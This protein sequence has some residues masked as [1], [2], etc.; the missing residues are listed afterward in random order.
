MNEFSVGWEEWVAL[1]EL[2]LPALKVKTDTGAKT[3]ALHAFNIQP[4]G[5]NTRPRV[6]FGIH[7]I[8]GRNDI[9]IYCSA[10]VVAVREVTSSNGSVELRYV[11]NTPVTIGD[12][13]WDIEVTLTNRESMA[14]RMLLGRTALEGL[15]VRPG[16]SF[17]QP[18]LSYDLYSKLKKKT[19]IKRSL[20]IAILTREPDNYSTRKLVEAAEARDH[21]VELIDTSKCYLDIQ[22]HT[23][24]VHYNGKSLPYYDVVIPRIGASLTFYG[25][26]VVRQFQAMGTFCLNTAEAIG[27][28]RD[29]LAAHQILARHHI[30]M[31]NTAFASSPEDTDSLINLAGGA[32]LILKLL[33]HSTQGK[34]A[35]LT[36][37]Q[38]AAAAVISAF[39][40]LD[41]HFIA[42]E[43]IK[44]AASSNIRCVVIGKR[45]VAS[46][47]RT[48]TNDDFY[49]RRPADA[50]AKKVRVTKE[51]RILAV[52]ASG[53]LG[54]NVSG[55]DIIRTEN[56]PKVL[57]VSS[58]PSLQDI[59]RVT[60]KDVASEIMEFIETKVQPSIRPSIIRRSK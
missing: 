19:P 37:T 32:P 42:Q 58:S 57:K 56:G 60:Q 40:G 4:F 9:E 52:K 54:F 6:R 12:R 38:N 14:Y 11:I 39:R 23:P 46:V 48:S 31:P 16:A 1:P 30:P 33:H 50:N 41:A 24:E 26:A 22:S 49:S 5:T 18:Q 53:A 15:T 28:S 29:K 44:E 45:V 59:E 7:P 3:S 13:T 35:V 27:A 36:E 2:G 25:M 21:V 47:K 51:E 55:V 10:R 43:F 20:R 34:S 17:E 8:P